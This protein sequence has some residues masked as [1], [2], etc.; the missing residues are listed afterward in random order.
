MLK[1]QKRE[2]KLSDKHPKST[3]KALK[4]IVKYVQSTLTIA[5]PVFGVCLIL[6]SPH[7]D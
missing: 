3:V 2:I 4:Q 6:N 1:K 7:S 5:W